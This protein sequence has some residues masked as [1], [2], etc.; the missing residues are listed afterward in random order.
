[1]KKKLLLLAIVGA[2]LL[3]AGPVLADGDFYV[4]AGGGAVG[5]KITSLPYT[6]NNSGFYFLSGDLTTA[7]NGITVAVDNVTIDFMGFSLAHTG[8]RGGTGIYMNGRTNVEIRN[9][10]V[11]GF[12]DGIY[13]GTGYGHRVI[14]V[15][16][17]NND[18]SI[19]FNGNSHL[20]KDCTCS[21]NAISGIFVN[22]GAIT[23]SVACNNGSYGI[24]LNGPGSVIG[25]IVNNNTIDGFNLGTGNIVVD[26]NSASGNG[27]N[28]NGGPT[29]PVY[30][31]INAGR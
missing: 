1:M 16:G 29:N 31:G 28:Y 23:G 3:S 11:R 24:R 19:V 20:V 13:E 27:T 5:T 21:N 30:W 12:S 14:N 2:V 17:T 9:G 25:N 15:R 4:I 10:T 22:S 8:A 7:G 18:M 6:I 26:R